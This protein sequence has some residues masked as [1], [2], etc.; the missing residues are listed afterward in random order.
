MVATRYFLI[1]GLVVTI[2]CT[3]VAI[4]PDGYCDSADDVPQL[5]FT[6]S[7]GS[8]VFVKLTDTDI[9]TSTV[10]TEKGM[11]H[12]SSVFNLG[13]DRMPTS[14]TL[15]SNNGKFRVSISMSLS[16]PGM[17][18]QPMKLYFGDYTENLFPLGG[19]SCQIPSSDEKWLS[20]NQ[21]YVTS[22]YIDDGTGTFVPYDPPSGLKISMRWS[23]SEDTRFVRYFCDGDVIGSRFYNPGDKLGDIPAAPEKIVPFIGWYDSLGEKVDSDTVYNYE[24]DMDFHTVYDID[25]STLVILILI[26]LIVGLCAMLIVDRMD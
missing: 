7:D 6:Y 4:S 5:E 17:V 10:V 23:T 12:D 25:T 26:T 14:V 21:R 8:K 16:D 20:P 22:L 13:L 19:Y 2:L 11:T 3:S 15:H 18:G 24:G 1:T 9:A